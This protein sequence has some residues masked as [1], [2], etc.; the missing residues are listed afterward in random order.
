MKKKL[1]YV[2]NLD[3]EEFGEYQNDTAEAEPE[4]FCPI[5]HRSGTFDTLYSCKQEVEYTNGG[6]YNELYVLC[7]CRNCDGIFLSKYEDDD[8]DEEYKLVTSCPRTIENVDF[9]EEVNR[10]SP[11]FVTI[12]SQAAE[13]EKSGLDRIAGIGYRKALEFLVKDFCITQNPDK[14]ETIEK[15]PLSSCIK[16]YIQHPKTK[17]VAERAAW[18]GNDQTHYLQKHTDK[19]LDDLKLL[20][21]LTRHWIVLELETESAAL[22]TAKK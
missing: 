14:K 18:L 10:L 12:Y 7:F 13:A 20:I 5:C 16:D 6:N 11:E 17:L 2:A 15:A 1:K 22:I 21:K 3:Y 19:D 8:C 9:E 4:P